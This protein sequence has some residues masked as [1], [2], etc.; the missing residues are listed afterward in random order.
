MAKDWTQD[1]LMHQLI[2]ENYELGEKHQKAHDEIERLREAL[3]KLSCK[4]VSNCDW[5]HDDIC[6]SWI[7]R[8]ALKET[9]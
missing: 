8:A 1:E 7:A 3:Q 5:E 4:C 9:E 2:K 6:P